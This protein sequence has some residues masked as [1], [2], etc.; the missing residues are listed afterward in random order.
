[1]IDNNK[2]RVIA[3]VEKIRFRLDNN[4]EFPEIREFLDR[5]CLSGE[6][7]NMS[8]FLIA[9]KVADL[10][11]PKIFPDFLIS[12]IEQMYEIEIEEGNADAMND[13]GSLYYGG[14]RGFPQDFDKA[15]RYYTMAAEHGCRVSQENLGYCYYYGRNGEPD[16]EKAFH[17]FAL[18]A[19]DG[20]LISLYKIGDMYLNGYYVQKNE[21]E[22]FYI[23]MRCL[24]TMTEEAEKY[25]AGPVYLRL[26]KMFLN[27]IGTEENL[28]NALI[29]F[30]KAEAFL[31]DMVLDG[32]IKYKKS[33]EAAIRGHAETGKK[34]SE[35]LPE[36][37]WID[38]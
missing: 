19:F 35:K 14:D 25:A 21:K 15:V 20:H 38:E 27:G 9:G 34:L 29:C 5:L 28:K 30:Q 11:M 26:G 12:F 7:K 6:L 31:Y 37:E 36:G 1:M 33:L 32:D 2:L 23:Y 3:G 18:G 10:D 17:C 4:D 8:P 24:D 16:Y 22:A 13:L